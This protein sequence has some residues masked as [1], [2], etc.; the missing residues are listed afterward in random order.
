MKLIHLRKGP[1]KAAT[2]WI[3][4]MVCLLPALIS[5]SDKNE[6]AEKAA[7]P[8]DTESFTFFDIGRTTKFS[9]QIR[10]DLEEKLG[11]DAIERRDVLDLEIN[12]QG[13]IK[14]YFPPL[15]D[16][17]QQLNFPPRERVEHNTVKLMYRYAQKQNVPF[18]Y[19][20]LVFSDYT[21]T[22]I[23]FKIHFK[24]DEANI[25]ET[26]KKKYG[27]PK[28]IDWKE[29][30]GQSM[31]WEKDNDFLIASLVPDQFGHHEYQ[32]NIYYVDNLK[33]LIDTE[34]KEKEEKERQR[35][36]TGKTAF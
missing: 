36:K 31:Y 20:E 11:R 5:C 32:I 30:N 24:K 13:F 7:L 10:D 6:P 25:I 35:V 33:K 8:A 27:N 26:L 14:K 19:V 1:F 28:I 17:N 22:P 18:D 2:L 4:F 16:L 34:R 29:N 12:Y 21:K 3:A 23:M 15:D 9:D